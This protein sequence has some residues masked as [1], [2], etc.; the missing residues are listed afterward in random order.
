M[1][2]DYIDAAPEN[3]INLYKELR[4]GGKK[5]KIIFIY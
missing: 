4:T 2:N 5:A 3:W 1:N